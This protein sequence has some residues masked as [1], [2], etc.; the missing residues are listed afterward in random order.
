MGDRLC[1]YMSCAKDSN[2]IINNVFRKIALLEETVSK[3]SLFSGVDEDTRVW[4]ASNGLKKSESADCA[5]DCLDQH[6]RSLNS[7]QPMFYRSYQKKP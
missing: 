5:T 1:I 4:I 6:I 3:Q 7:T 2:T